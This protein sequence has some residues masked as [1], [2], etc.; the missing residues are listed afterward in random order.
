VAVSDD[1]N[2]EKLSASY[3]EGFLEIRLPKRNAGT[4]AKT[5]IKVE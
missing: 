1:V 5:E 4:A 2:M 3:H